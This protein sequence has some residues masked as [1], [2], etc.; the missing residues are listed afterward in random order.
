MQTFLRVLRIAYAGAT[1]FLG[2]FGAI[3]GFAL[4]AVGIAG[5]ITGQIIWSIA[6]SVIAAATGRL[7][8]QLPNLHHS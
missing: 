5:A 8:R 2:W 4:L 1:L 6:C 3:V 7:E